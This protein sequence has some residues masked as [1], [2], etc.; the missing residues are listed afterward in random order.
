LGEVDRASEAILDE[1]QAGVLEQFFKKYG[2]AVATMLRTAGR[3]ISEEDAVE[4]IVDFFRQEFGTRFPDA[5]YEDLQAGFKASWQQGQNFPV[6]KDWKTLPVPTETIEWF[7]K[8][9]HFDVSS[10]MLGLE[11]P[12]RQAVLEALKS[13]N[14]PARIQAVRSA[15]GTAF[16]D[17]GTRNHLENIFRNLSSRSSVFSRV[18]RYEELKI[19]DI[20]IVA[21]MDRRTSALCKTM[22]GRR[23]KV[24]KVSSFV[25]EF[26]STPYDG[27]GFWKNFSNPPD[28]AFRGNLERLSTSDLV[29]KLGLPL[30]PYHFRCRTTTVV[31]QK[32]TVKNRTGEELTGEIVKPPGN[33]ETNRHYSRFQDWQHLEP[34]ERLS[35]IETLQKRARWDA[36]WLTDHFDLH[37]PEFGLKTETD[38]S[39]LSK[40]VLQEFDRVLLYTDRVTEEKRM[41]FYNR[42]ERAFVAVDDDGN[43]RTM[44]TPNPVDLQRMALIR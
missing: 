20:E 39:A 23:I 27:P 24:E 31:S 11:E 42:A 30:P 9:N 17:P 1:I 8:A 7:A 43:I 36:E 32:V 18:K 21:I 16:N 15:L 41:G 14:T 12:V 22:D 38:F 10:K 35:K 13:G 5:V 44:F 4:R 34:L 25:D 28:S 3:L 33:E 19:Q 6:R 2:A 40:K 29:D 26:T 37:G